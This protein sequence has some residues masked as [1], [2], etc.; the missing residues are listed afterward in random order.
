ME[1]FL[2]HRTEEEFLELGKQS[3]PEGR[4]FV[5]AEPEGIN[6][7]LVTSKPLESKN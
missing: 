7:I 1:W 4:H 5:M 2:I 6:L 3:A